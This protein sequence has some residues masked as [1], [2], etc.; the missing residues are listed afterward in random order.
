[1]ANYVAAITGQPIRNGGATVV[2]GRTGRIVSNAPST[3]V[4]AKRTGQ[5]GNVT[6][7]SNSTFTKA[8]V[9]GGRYGGMKAGKYIMI[10]Y[11]PEIA[12][13]TS[14]LLRSSGAMIQHRTVKSVLNVRTTRVVTAGWNIKGQL[15]TNPTVAVDTFGSVDRASNWTQGSPGRWFFTVNGK[16]ITTATLPAK[17]D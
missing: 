7:P 5:Y 17:T 13:L 6:P 14:T 2:Y 11:C 9:S 3:T 15:L 1:M 12:G 16:V 4:V 10:G 8:A